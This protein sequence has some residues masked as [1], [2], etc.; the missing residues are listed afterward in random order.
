MSAVCKTITITDE[1]DKWI[2]AQINAGEFTS[3]SEYIRDL[4]RRDQ[5]RYAGIEKIRGALIEA[6]QSGEP[7]AFDA[8][9]FKQEMIVKHGKHNVSG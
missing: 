4:I 2:T 1:Q 6:E 5:A 9:A 3:D 7:K 8:G